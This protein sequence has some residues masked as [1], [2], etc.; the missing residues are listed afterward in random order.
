MIRLPMLESTIENQILDTTHKQGDGAK[1]IFK[2]VVNAFR[3][4]WD[5]L[6]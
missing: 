4:A 3:L 2:H 6:K 5:F 1:R